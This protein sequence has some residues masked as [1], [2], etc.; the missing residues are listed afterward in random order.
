MKTLA[1]LVLFPIIANATSRD[2]VTSES[3]VSSVDENVINNG[4]QTQLFHRKLQLSENCQ[5]ALEELSANEE[6]QVANQTKFEEAGEFDFG[7]YC[8]TSE[9]KTTCRVD[10]GRFIENKF[11]IHSCD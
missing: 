5:V 6:F 4:V 7:S 1:I 3:I 8:T 10:N 11:E 2:G 9:S